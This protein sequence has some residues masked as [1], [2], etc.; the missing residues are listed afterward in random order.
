MINNMSSHGLQV[1]LLQFFVQPHQKP[2]CN[3]ALE[4]CNA[5]GFAYIQLMGPAYGLL[6][7]LLSWSAS[8]LGAFFVEKMASHRFPVIIPHSSFD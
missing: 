4:T 3:A 5:V 6:L 7:T 8:I 1:S 2:V